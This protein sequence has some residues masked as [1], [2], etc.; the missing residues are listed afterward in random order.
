MN[1]TTYLRAVETGAAVEEDTAARAARM[2]RH[3]VDLAGQVEVLSA[4]LAAAHRR[5]LGA[6]AL[7]RDQLG[8]LHVELDNLTDD[9]TGTA[10]GPGVAS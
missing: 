2:A 7:L 5:E 4:D 6:L 3:A 10:P 9:L 1:A 8:E